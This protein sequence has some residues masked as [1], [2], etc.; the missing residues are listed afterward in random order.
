MQEHY[1][2]GLFSMH[3]SSHLFQSEVSWGRKSQVLLKH[4]NALL[5]MQWDDIR[6][7][8]GAASVS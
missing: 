3:C 5:P 8:K 6:E 2:Y 4:P 7:M 1:A